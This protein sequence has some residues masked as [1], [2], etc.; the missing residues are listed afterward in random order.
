[1]F[2][3]KRNRFTGNSY[4]LGDTALRQFRWLHANRSDEEWRGF[5]N[6]T[7]GMFSR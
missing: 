6:D 3:S 2:L 4:L 1:M 5:G 7:T